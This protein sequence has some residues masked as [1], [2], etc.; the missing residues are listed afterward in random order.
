[1]KTVQWGA[2]LLLWILAMDVRPASGQCPSQNASCEC[3]MQQTVIRVY[4]CENLG[5]IAGLPDLGQTEDIIQVILISSSTVRNLFNNSF[6]GL[7]A[8]TLDVREIGIEHLHQNAFAGLENYIENIYLV[9]NDI[10]VLPTDIFSNMVHLRTLTLDRNSISA[11]VR[12]QFHGLQRLT[13]LGMESNDISSIQDGAFS[14]LPSLKYLYLQ[15][16]FIE[17]LPVGTFDNLENLQELN[18]INNRI[19]VLR[20]DIFSKLPVLTDLFMSSNFIEFLPESIFDKNRNLR[21]I[22][23]DDNHISSNFTNRHFVGPRLV[24]IL[25]VSYNNLTYF[26]PSTFHNLKKLKKLFLDNNNLRKLAESTF[27]GLDNIQELYLQHNSISELPINSFIGMPNLKILDLSRNR[28]RRIGFGIFDPFGLLEKLDV[29]RNEIESVENGPFLT[30]RSLE[31]LDVSWNRLPAVTNDWFAQE[32]WKGAT[33]PLRELYLHNNVIRH[34][35]AETFWPLK[36]LERLDI[37]VNRLFTLNETVFSES[38]ALKEVAIHDN[39]LHNISNGLFSSLKQIK[40]LDISHTCL[41]EIV[42]F[43]FEGMTALQRLDLSGGFISTLYPDSFR[44]TGPIAVLNIS[45]NNI[46]ALERPTFRYI[47]ETL[48]VVHLNHNA[49][50]MSGLADSLGFARNLKVADISYNQ[51]TNIYGVASLQQG[52]VLLRIMANPI[53]C[54]C[55]ASWLQNY[56]SLAGFERVLCE[57]PENLKGTHAVCFPFSPEC[58]QQPIARVYQDF[59]VSPPSM[60]VVESVSSSENGTDA[61]DPFTYGVKTMQDFLTYC[62]EPEIPI[63]TRR[64]DDKGGQDTNPL[65]SALDIEVNA[66]GTTVYVRWQ[67]QNNSKILGYKVTCREFG[68]NSVEKEQLISNLDQTSFTL[69]DLNLESNYIICVGLVLD[70]NSVLQ[71]SRSCREVTLYLPTRR[72]IPDTGESFPL[73]PVIGTCIAVVV[74]LVVILAVVI[75]CLRRKPKDE[76]EKYMDDAL[77]DKM[78]MWVD[79]FNYNGGVNEQ[80]AEQTTVEVDIFAPVDVV[81]KKERQPEKQ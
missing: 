35:D 30:L 19:S 5:D 60:P 29:S 24:E 4:Q 79:T 34:I 62:T 61:E 17:H 52:G 7:K 39:P 6:A 67:Y 16:N 50:T 77:R 38:T 81:K 68:D 73:M 71:D 54:D 59:C 14:G 55:Y 63:T 45:Y 70:D 47:D 20:P 18:M 51:L 12:D 3:V 31:I 76:E 32:D 33:K 23:L 36:N 22:D 13:H 10:R 48:E 75:L 26:H 41:T 1:M 58:S 57:S 28:I 46:S 44:N 27:E 53:Q 69:E 25:D 74:V 8:R 21:T 65:P 15:N 2:V 64:P 40:S 9:G 66:V 78:G 49:L 37:S 43:T 80:I 72:P 56:V 11:I 42:P